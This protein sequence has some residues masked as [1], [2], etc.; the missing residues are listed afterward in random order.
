[1]TEEI[2]SMI[3]FELT[4]HLT[5]MKNYVSVSNMEHKA[6]YMVLNLPYSTGLVSFAVIWGTE[7]DHCICLDH[8][9]VAKFKETLSIKHVLF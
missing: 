3:I 2:Y 8:S 6:D 1:M 5:K 7:R 9:Q 4:F